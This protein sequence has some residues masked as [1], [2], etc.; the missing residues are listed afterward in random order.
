MS[1]AVAGQHQMDPGK[2]IGFKRALQIGNG[3]PS[4]HRVVSFRCPAVTP[5]RPIRA[6]KAK[7][8]TRIAQW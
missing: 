5:T 8:S 7:T 6:M 4:E 3:F 2:P 1:V